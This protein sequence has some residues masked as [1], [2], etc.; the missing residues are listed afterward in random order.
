[1][2]HSTGKAIVEI[3][4]RPRP[5]KDLIKEVR[6]IKNGAASQENNKIKSEVEPFRTKI[7]SINTTEDISLRTGEF[8][9]CNPSRKREQCTV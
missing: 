2:D 3:P 7:D 8:E 4:I 1:M 5:V 9:N 6:K